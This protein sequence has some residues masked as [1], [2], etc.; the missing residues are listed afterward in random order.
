MPEPERPRPLTFRVRFL[1]RLIYALGRLIFVTLRIRVVGEDA[2]RAALAKGFGGIQA[3]W[4]GLTLVPGHRYAGRGHVALISL[5]RDGDIQNRNFLLMGY[6]TVRGST[7]RG[8]VRAT[9]E[10]VQL[11]RSG[12]VLSFTPDGPRGPARQAQPGVAFFA[13]KTGAPVLPIGVAA[14][15]GWKLATWDTYLIP[16]PFSRVVLHCGDPLWIGTGESDETAC[17]AVRAA[18]DQACADAR[19]ELTDTPAQNRRS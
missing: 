3:T 8:A 1:G 9:M 15:R 10:V 11:L 19:R 6:R 13:R 4:H 7:G 18:L 5:S 12:A 14:D 16:K 17:E 2:H